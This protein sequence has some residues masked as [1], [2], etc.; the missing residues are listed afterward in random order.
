M[1]VPIPSELVLTPAPCSDLIVDALTG[2]PVCTAGL[3]TQPVTG[4]FVLRARVAMEHTGVYNAGTLVAFQDE[5]HWVKVCFELG[6]HGFAS[7]CT[8]VTNGRS[9]DCSGARIDGDAVWLQL[10]RTGDVFTAHYSLDGERWLLSRILHLPSMPTLE[11][12]LGAQAPLGDPDTVRF[13]GCVL[14]EHG[15]ADPR[16]GR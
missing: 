9:D 16:A 11:V 13:S 10:A 3:E 15:L 5:R 1:P 6:E 8:V 12:G 2:V 4:D 7:E 14:E